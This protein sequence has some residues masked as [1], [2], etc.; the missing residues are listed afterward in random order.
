MRKLPWNPHPF[1]Q[2][3]TILRDSPK[4]IEENQNQRQSQIIA[5]ERLPSW[6]LSLITKTILIIFTTENDFPNLF[7]CLL[8]AFN[9]LESENKNFPEKHYAGA[10]ANI[11]QKPCGASLKSS[12]QWQII[13]VRNAIHGRMN[14]FLV[15]LF[16]FLLFSFTNFLNII[17]I[18]HGGLKANKW[19]LKFR[20]IKTNL[21][22]YWY[23]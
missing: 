12:R 6:S 13:E 10:R 17:G 16:H 2:I 20:V 4:Q 3:V 11:K 22:D 19:I 23:V 7:L 21:P 5:G 8:I 9:D 14:Q 18:C 15:C 1:P